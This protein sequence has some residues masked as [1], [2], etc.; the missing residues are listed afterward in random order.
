MDRWNL[1]EWKFSWNDVGMSGV[2][3]FQKWFPY[4]KVDISYPGLHDRIPAPKAIWQEIVERYL[5]E[6]NV[7]GQRLSVEKRDSILTDLNE[8]LQKYNQA[9]YVK[10]GQLLR[11]YGYA[12]ETHGKHEKGK[13]WYENVRAP[14]NEKGG[15]K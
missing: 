6:Q 8:L 14:A 4:S 1:H 2:E 7:V 10:L 3:E 9:P 15:E 5:S 11:K 12:L 13:E